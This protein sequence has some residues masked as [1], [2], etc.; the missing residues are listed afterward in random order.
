MTRISRK[1]LLNM[2]SMLK[3]GFFNPYRNVLGFHLED[4]IFRTPLN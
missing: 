1:P 3:L 2:F 4:A